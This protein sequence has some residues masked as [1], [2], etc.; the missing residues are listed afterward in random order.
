[1]NKSEL[2]QKL[3]YLICDYCDVLE[4]DEHFHRPSIT[5]SKVNAFKIIDELENLG[6]QYKEKDN[7]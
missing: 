3:T 1:M 2:A 5:L 7:E 6:F 4:S